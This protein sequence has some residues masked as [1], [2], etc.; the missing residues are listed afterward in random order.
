MSDAHSSRTT[1]TCPGKCALL[2]SLAGC[3]EP[4]I[5][6]REVLSVTGGGSGESWIVVHE[7]EGKGGHEDAD[8][9]RY[10]VYQCQATGCRP[11]SVLPG[12]TNG[13]E[14]TR[15]CGAEV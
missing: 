8:A 9:N 14:R 1:W 2:W 13:A 10:I 11:V 12:S 7:V 5:T 6:Q 15:V 3:I 4:H